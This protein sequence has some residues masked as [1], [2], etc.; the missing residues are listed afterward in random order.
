MVGKGFR[1]R[2]NGQTSLLWNDEMDPIISFLSLAE[3]GEKGTIPHTLA[4][5]AVTLKHLWTGRCG[6]SH[7][8]SQ[9][10]WLKFRPEKPQWVH[11]PRPSKC[12][13][14]IILSS[15]LHSHLVN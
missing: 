14:T 3:G 1:I 13:H 12:L 9:E 11:Y 7:V 5:L 10:S 2:V 8:K 6:E 4:N 15:A